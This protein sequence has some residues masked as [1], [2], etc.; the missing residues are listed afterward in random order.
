MAVNMDSAFFASQ[1]AVR[2]MKPAGAGS[3]I[4]F[5]SIN[6]LFGPTEMPGYVAAKSALLGLNKALARQYGADGI[7]VNVI[8][9]GW[10]ATERQL[11]NWLSPEIETEWLAQTALRQRIMPDD[12][13]RLAL[14]LASDDSRLITSQQFVIDGG[15]I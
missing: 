9:P 12:V 5:S 8:L 1:A 11:T 15:K 3:I 7:R 14:F 2:V 4:N 10:V 13:A 6:A